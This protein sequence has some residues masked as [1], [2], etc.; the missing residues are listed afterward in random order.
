MSHNCPMLEW[1]QSINSLERSMPYYEL[2]MVIA[3]FLSV[4]ATGLLVYIAWKQISELNKKSK[5][6]HER[7]RKKATIE[8]LGDLWEKSKKNMIKLPKLD[9]II[10]IRVEEYPDEYKPVLNI[11]DTFERMALG[12]LEGVYD[13]KL[14]YCMVGKVK[15]KNTY[16]F[17]ESHIANLIT[18]DKDYICKFV[19]LVEYY[20]AQKLEPCEKIKGEAPL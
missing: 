7:I 10:D 17:F 14:F 18:A 20:N 2:I 5:E 11:F 8:T 1:L 15:L 16:E 9:K 13:K 3:T 12:L 6:E 4:I 19:K